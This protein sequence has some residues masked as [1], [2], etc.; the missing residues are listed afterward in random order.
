MAEQGRSALGE[1]LRWVGP[2]LLMAGAAIGVSHL[3]QAT[4]AGASFG[5]DLLLG[6]VVVV[7]L[8]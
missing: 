1:V 5:F 8:S 3:M 4:R 6:L 7:N 2:G